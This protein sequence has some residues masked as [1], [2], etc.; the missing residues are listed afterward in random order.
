MKHFHNLHG[1]VHNN[2]FFL[3]S[4]SNSESYYLNQEPVASDG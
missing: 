2:D 4:S 1:D 3:K